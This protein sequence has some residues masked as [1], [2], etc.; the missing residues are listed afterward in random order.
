[1]NWLTVFMMANLIGIGANLDNTAVGIAY[2]IKKIKFPHLVNLIVNFVGLCT[3]LL[4]A[5]MGEVIAQYTPPTTAKLISCIILCG[6]G[7]FILYST[8]LHPKIS[9]NDDQITL[10]KP[11]IKQGILLGLGLSFTNLASGFSAT[12]SNSAT[13]WTTVLSIAAW[14]YIMIFIG[15]LLSIGMISNLLGKYSSL[16]AAGLLIGVG[17]HQIIS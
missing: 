11:G 9:R 13:L 12:L 16:V 4:G 14:G 1:M 6:I 8:Y 15:N 5:Y 17:I 10:S 3:A 7:L 2:G